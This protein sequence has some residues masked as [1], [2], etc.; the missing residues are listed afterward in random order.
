[1]RIDSSVSVSSQVGTSL[2][3]KEPGAVETVDLDPDQYLILIYSVTQ[4]FLVTSLFYKT[5]ITLDHTTSSMCFKRFFTGPGQ[6]EKGAI[7]SFNKYLWIDCMPGMV[8]GASDEMVNKT[9]VPL[10]QQGT[11]K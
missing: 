7:S 6:K 9:G 8:L 5:E 3:R 1:M 11:R 2:L 10:F 4:T